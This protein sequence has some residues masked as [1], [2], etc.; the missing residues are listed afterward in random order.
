[1]N[2]LN[3]DLVVGELEKALLDGLSRA[4]DIGLDDDV[5]VL[6]LT[7]FNRGKEVVKSD[8]LVLLELL[9]LG[10]GLSLLD[11]LPCKALVVNGVKSVT[12]LRHLVETHDLNGDGGACGVDLAALVVRHNS[13]SADGSARDYDIA[14]SERAVLNEQS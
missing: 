14:R 12:R 10:L 7:L 11:K 6:Q 3:S 13:D 9:F 1:M 5:E 2:D 4:L 8:L